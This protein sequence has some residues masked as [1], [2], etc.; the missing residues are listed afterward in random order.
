MEFLILKQ[1]KIPNHRFELI[2]WEDNQKIR[3]YIDWWNCNC[4]RYIFIKSGLLCLFETYIFV[5]SIL[6]KSENRT[7]LFFPKNILT[8]FLLISSIFSVTLPF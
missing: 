5:D 6:E 1:D 8:R 7:N 3:K 2:C 4:S